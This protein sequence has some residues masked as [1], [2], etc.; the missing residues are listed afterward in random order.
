M[1]KKI[2]IFILTAAL[3]FI[4]LSCGKENDDNISADP[5][6][7][8]TNIINEDDDGIL[9][10]RAYT[11]DSL[12]PDLNFGNDTVNIYYFGENR[13]D[14]YDAVGEYSGDI[15]YDT[16]YNRNI[17]VSEKLKVNFNWIKGSD[18]WS[19]FPADVAKAILAD[20]QDYDIILE[21]NSRA[22]QHSLEGYLVNIIDAPY[23]D[24]TKPWWYVQFMDTGSIDTSKR[25]FVTGDLN[26]TTLL[27]ASSVYFNKPM[28]VNYFNDIN[29]LYNS[30]LDSKWTHEYMMQFCRDVYTDVN[31]NNIA[32]EADI[33]GFKY[34][35]WGVPNYLSMST[36]LPFSKRDAEGYP[37]MDLNN[38][39]AVK[40]SETLYKM[41]YSDNISL[42]YKDS[43]GSLDSDFLQQKTLFRVGMFS[44]ANDIR[45]SDFDYGILPYPKLY[46]N[47]NYM[48]AAATVNGT[49]AAIPVSAPEEKLEMS[50]AVIE[51]LC[52][53]SYRNVIPAWY[54]TA[55]KV[56]YAN[57]EVD[58]QMIDI[59]YDHIDTSFI[60]MADKTIGIGSIFTFAVF[61]A[62]SESAY[63]SYYAKN[64]S[65]YTKKWDNMIEK[66]KNLP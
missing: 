8:E 46:E 20:V 11:P 6:N 35:E 65:S 38:E 63:V 60:M 32:D 2:I 4:L 10:G 56:K 47:L 44:T 55:L 58:A 30:V 15:V 40:W 9:T 22:F 29:L 48:S 24:Y 16:V 36:G 34:T 27:G 59:I 23:I 64:E 26:V 18:D 12:P 51:A 25:Y 5:R 41:L 28:F 50:C 62:K 39:D 3:L 52:S 17:T 21:E 31:G 1:F 57:A 45:K 66:Y 43:S 13:C 33:F 54:D 53:E 14:K 42:F 49:G 19:T 61:N 37:V 7:T